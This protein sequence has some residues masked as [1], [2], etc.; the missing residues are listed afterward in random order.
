MVP[1]KRDQAKVAMFHLHNRR[2]QICSC[3]YGGLEPI[4]EFV[5]TPQAGCCWWITMPMPCHPCRIVDV[6][7]GGDYGFEF[8]F[9]RAG[10]HPLQAWDGELPGT[11]PMLAGTGE[12]PCAIID[13]R[14]Q[15]WVT[16]WGDNRIELYQ[17]IIKAVKSKRLARLPSWAMRCFA[18]W[19][20]QS[21]KQGS[22]Y[23]TDWVDRAVTTYTV[24]AVSGS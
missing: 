2:G 17:P 9:G 8:R 4:L 5:A 16:S 1:S 23:V 20:W 21:D 14:G 7:Q 18:Q 11:L 6:M 13:F 10:T 12:A 15:Y 24:K 19:I 3:R 22:L